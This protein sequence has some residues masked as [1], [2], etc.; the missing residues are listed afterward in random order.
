MSVDALS[1]MRRQGVRAQYIYIDGHHTFD[2][3]LIDFCCSDK[4]LEAGGVI[5]L[6]D[7][8]MPSIKAVVSF[9]KNNFQHYER[10]KVDCDKICCLKKTGEDIRSW[11]HF[12]RFYM[13]YDVSSI[14]HK[15]NRY[16]KMLKIKFGN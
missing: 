4:I 10:V 7:T 15:Y 9:I 3:A 1:T 2:A 11:D 14:K 6:D 16:I 12:V 5:I 8:W 13:S